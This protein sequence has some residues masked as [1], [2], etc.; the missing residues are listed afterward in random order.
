MTERSAGF[1]YPIFLDLQD[2]LVVV[3][4][5]GIV[6]MRKLRRL[7]QAGAR[8]RL[9]DPCLSGEPLADTGVES[10]GHVFAPT[11]LEGAQLVFACTDS[12]LVNQQV[13]EDAAQLQIF[14][15][16]A[17]LSAAGDFILPAVFTQE[18]LWVAVSTAG[19]N[20]S[21]AVEIRDRLAENIPDYWGLSLEIMACVRRKKLTANIDDQYNQQVLRLF[22]SEQ[23]LPLLESGN[24]NK[25]NAL[26]VETFGDEFSLEQLRMSLPEG[27]S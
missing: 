12:L 16:R 2:R 22:W 13:F 8:V 18:P 7:L 1:T 24:V 20:P 19:G 9:V 15:C 4:G 10:V 14:C 25:I 21:L 26:L 5:A 27:M 11:D 23:L 17:D 6:G 3:V